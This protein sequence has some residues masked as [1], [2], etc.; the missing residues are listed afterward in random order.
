MSIELIFG[1][2]GAIA[3]TA[4]IIFSYISYAHSKIETVNAFYLNDRDPN[5]IEARRIVHTLPEGYDPIKV[6]EEHGKILTILILSYDQAGI[7]V[8]KRK[9]PFWIFSEG[10]CGVAVVNFYEKLT[11]YIAEKRKENRL[12]A[13]NF[14]YLKNKISEE[15]PQKNF[16]KTK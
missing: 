13:T 5:F 15:V 3:G 1:L 9:L 10:G 11:P 2:I 12:Y 4:G 6:R 7:L 14:E 16:A 8:K